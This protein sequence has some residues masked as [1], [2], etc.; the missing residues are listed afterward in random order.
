MPTTF[1]SIIFIVFGVNFWHMKPVF[2]HSK[3][4]IKDENKSKDKENL[5]QMW[6]LRKI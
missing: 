6:Y 4:F 1:L 3:I 2:S 5:Y